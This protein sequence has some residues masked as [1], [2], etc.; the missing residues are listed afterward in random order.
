MPRPSARQEAPKLL[1]GALSKINIAQAMEL[2]DAIMH[3][4]LK[5]RVEADTDWERI[6]GVDLD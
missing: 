5:N 1:Q 3:Q 2:L 6:L 4:M